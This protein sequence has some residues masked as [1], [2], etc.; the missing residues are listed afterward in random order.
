MDINQISLTT[1]RRLKKARKDRDLSHVALSEAIKKKYGI[2]ISKDTLINYEVETE[3]HSRAFA[4]KGMKIEY[5]LCFADFYGVSCDYLLGRT[6]DPHIDATVQSVHEFTGLSGKA[7]E[8]LHSYPKG[9]LQSNFMKRFF[10]DLLINQEI[11]EYVPRAIQKYAIAK[12]TAMFEAQSLTRSPQSEREEI[13][14]LGDGKFA[15][16]TN[17]AADLFYGDAISIAQGDIAAVID[18]MC[19]EV[20]RSYHIGAPDEVAIK[21]H[22]WTIY[23][24]DDRF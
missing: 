10:D 2:N 18:G 22:R 8:K 6:D 13:Y 4:N 16:S 24:E 23:S 1:A 20:L 7:I 14:S 15:I 19:E 9:S 5:L 3:N 12:K 11:A 21:N 17:S